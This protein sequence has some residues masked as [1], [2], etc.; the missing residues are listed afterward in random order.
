[1]KIIG[2]DLAKLPMT[3]GRA[4]KITYLNG[5]FA[6]VFEKVSSNIQNNPKRRHGFPPVNRD[7]PM[8][9]A[10]Y[11]QMLNRNFSKLIELDLDNNKCF[12][13]TLTIRSEE[14]NT[15]QKISDR[16]K[17]FTNCVRF[18]K[19]VDNSYLGAVRFI[20]VQEKGFFHIHCILVFDTKNIK[21]T[22]KDL[23]RMWDWGF[24]KVKNI[25]YLTGLIDYLT[26]PKHGA[27]NDQTNKFTRYPKSVK[28]IYICPNLP[29]G[30]TE[31]IDIPAEQYFELVNDE[32]C[33]GHIK[34]HKYF[35]PITQKIR[36]CIDKSVLVQIPQKRGLS[37]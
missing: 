35:D 14:H 18:S 1:M 27:K 24:V 31:I 15:Y 9:K 20:E 4:K 11:K 28:V 2:K 30:K 8:S 37:K 22:W 19:K 26:N 36:V 32:N 33:F 6:Y 13:L 25:Y 23:H 34:F 7:E 3:S 29:K 12:S 5:C 17:Y 10:S 21:L 16:F